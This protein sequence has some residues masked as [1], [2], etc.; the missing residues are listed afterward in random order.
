MVNLN[1]SI[2]PDFFKSEERCG[3]HVSSKMKEVWAVQLDL[4]AEFDRV[5][6]KCDIQYVASGG[7]LLGAVRH[8]GYIPWDD[9]IDIMMMRDQYEKLCSVGPQEFKHPY[10]FQTEKTD[11]G[12]HRWFARLRNSET[13]A[14]QT[15]ENDMHLKNNQGIFI[16]V[17][18]LDNVN[19]DSNLYRKQAKKCSKYFRL[20]NF[21]YMI[22][23]SIVWGS[24]S[25]LKKAVRKLLQFFC[26]KMVHKL[27]LTQK[28]YDILDNA[29]QQYNNVETEYVSLLSFQVNNL[30]H[31]LRSNAIKHIVYSD[32]EFLKMP[33]IANYDEHLRHK[34]G[35]YMTPA[36]NPNYHGDIFFDTRLSYLQYIKQS[37]SK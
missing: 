17:F 10:F 34:Y 13:T 18:P 30:E 22:E 33:I 32:F 35:D 14:I 20:Y 25:Q 7:T 6:K 1:L 28:V 21:L 27:Q 15:R 2:P 19:D 4:Y 12:G 9:D 16:D 37:S 23:Y 31:A 24:D 3:Y 5:C 11:P 26:G 8:H 29:Y 36:N